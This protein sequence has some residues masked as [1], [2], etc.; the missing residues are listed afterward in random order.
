M[1]FSRF[2]TKGWPHNLPVIVK[3]RDHPNR[4]LKFEPV[5]DHC[6]WKGFVVLWICKVFSKGVKDREKLLVEGAYLVRLLSTKDKPFVL[7]VVYVDE[8]YNAKVMFM[9]QDG[10]EVCILASIPFTI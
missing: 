9:W 8:Y 3:T 2:S 4:L 10:E 6:L 1:H 5:S 7:P